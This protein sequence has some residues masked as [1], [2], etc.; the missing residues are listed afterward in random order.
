[1]F[2]DRGPTFMV[3]PT[4]AEHFKVLKIMYFG[5]LRIIERI[6]HTAAFE[7]ILL[8]PVDRHRFRKARGFE[9]RRCHIDHMRK[10]R[11]DLT[12]ALDG[13]W[14]VYDGPVSRTAPV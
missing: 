10:L 3:N 11:T 8:H 6:Q 1:M 5:R 4:V 12:L 2:R 7:G 14:P 9:Y 13:L